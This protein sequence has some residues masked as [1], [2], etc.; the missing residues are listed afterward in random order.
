MTMVP[1]QAK[2]ATFVFQSEMVTFY[3]NMIIED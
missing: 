3:I 2:K 1:W